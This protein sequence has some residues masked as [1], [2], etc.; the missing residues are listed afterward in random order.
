MVPQIQMLPG[1]S[2]IESE[3]RGLCRSVIV[4]VCA[5][6]QGEVHHAGEELPQWLIGALQSQQTTERVKGGAHSLLKA[7][8]GTTDPEQQRHHV[9][10]GKKLAE[11][12]KEIRRQS[13]QGAAHRVALSI[14]TPNSAMLPS[15]CL[16]P[17]NRAN[18]F[19]PGLK[20]QSAAG[21]NP[22]PLFSSRPCHWPS[23]QVR[24]PSR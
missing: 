11:H 17:P 7:Q 22:P 10:R 18:R 16:L 24:C 9:A 3:M 1:E 4:E 8:R 12:D 23:R 15:V 5:L 20:D 19:G 21:P 2:R 14:G 13:E 6:E